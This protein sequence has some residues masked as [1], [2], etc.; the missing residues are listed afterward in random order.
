MKLLTIL[1]ILMTSLTMASQDEGSWG[2]QLYHSIS[3]DD[4]ITA[5]VFTSFHHDNTGTSHMGII[6]ES[7][8]LGSHEGVVVAVESAYLFDNLKIVKHKRL[9]IGPI[10]NMGMMYYN[11]TSNWRLQMGA[12][13]AYVFNGWVSVN[14]SFVG[15]KENVHESEWEDIR[16]NVYVTSLGVS[17][18][19]YFNRKR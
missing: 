8:K 4:R 18:R 16:K 14:L 9:E 5:K 11:G 2:A 15:G 19:P 10:A 17:F 12:D 7:L 3:P 6:L 1:A 13:L